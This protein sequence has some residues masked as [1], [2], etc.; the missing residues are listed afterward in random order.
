MYYI[1]NQDKQIVAADA[2]FLSLL[3]IQSLQELFTQV[4]SGQIN[5]NEADDQTLEVSTASGTLTLDRSSHPLSTLMGDL[6]LC[7]VSEPAEEEKHDEEKGEEP[8]AFDAEAEEEKI[9]FSIE[10]KPEA[11]V[12]EPAAVEEKAKEIEDL[13]KPDTET[14]AEEDTVAFLKTTEENESEIAEKTPEAPEAKEEETIDFLKMETE[15]EENLTLPQEREEEDLGK[16]DE[17]Y[18]VVEEETDTINLLP[19]EEIDHL[20]PEEIA[21]EDL[22]V[23][24]EAISQTL[25]ISKEDYTQFLNEFIDKAIEEEEAV[26]NVDNP[27]H[28]KAVSSLYKLSQ[29]LHLTALS[30]ILKSVTGQ[31]GKGEEKSIEIFY[32][33]LSN[34]TTYAETSAPETPEPEETSYAKE[35]CHLSLE[36]V[37][38]IHFDFQPQQASEDLG[39]PLELII[40]FT[41]DFIVQAHEAEEIF[42]DACKK[43]DIDTIHRTAH[44][45]KGVASNL[46]IVPLAETLEELQF[47][48]DTSRFEP[49]LKKYWGQFL[50]LENLMD[51]L[52]DKKGGE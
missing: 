10:E 21:A 15:E 30:D 40:E 38:P 47:C 24:A 8:I 46:R 20:K 2:D 29:M 51:I 32:H 36:G 22:V 27:D 49:L 34:M 39:L 19:D 52:S 1:V 7:N 31:T 28:E 5:F 13:I 48:E 35:I 14:E 23:D 17:E 6:L 50:A 44:K 42:F 4:A 43:G 16:N 9:P 41:H 3:N 18:K 33:A 25:G 12:S 26:K 45:L 37:K 11:K